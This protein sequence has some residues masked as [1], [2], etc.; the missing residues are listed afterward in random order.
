MDFIIVIQPAIR[1][2]FLAA[3]YLL[4]LPTSI[5][6]EVGINTREIEPLIIEWNDAHN[7]RSTESFI[8][9]YDK[10]VLYYTEQLTKAKCISLKQKLFRE[11][12]DYH[13][14][15]ASN[16]KYKPYTAGF[17]K[18]DFTKEVIKDSVLWRY[19]AYILVSYEKGGYKIVGESDDDTDR[20]LNF[21]LK[22]GDQMDIPVTTTK[23]PEI[24]KIKSG[25][26]ARNN[27]SILALNSED[28]S[29]GAGVAVEKTLAEKETDDLV[30]TANPAA[31]PIH[32]TEEAVTLPL[33]YVYMFIGALAIGSLIL[34]LIGSRR[35]RSNKKPVSTSLVRKPYKHDFYDK[36]ESARFEKFVITLFDPLYFGAH[37]KQKK[38]EANMAGGTD[39]SPDPEF[40]FTHKETGVKFIIESL[41]IQKLDH[42]DIQIATSQKLRAYRQLDEDDGDL[43][44][45][46]GI[47]GRPDDPKEIYFIPAK[48]IEKPFIT[49]PQLQ[50]Y[51]KYG[52][53]FYHKDHKKLQ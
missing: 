1:I 21:Y 47:E 36:E 32:I 26:L 15:I 29:S 20:T 34:V 24:K 13:Q 45:V 41:Y 33:T 30:S 49:Y 14:Q 39:G 8:K 6:Q 12:P 35:K 4:Y 42:T 10:K 28:I 38:V 18:C 2:F 5:A 16:I 51:R 31:G 27:D 19:P 40:E 22:L 48:D 25:D 7:S 53:F 9:V 43:F 46:L 23:E 3:A 52:M 50:R 17:I 11:Y 37:S 44:L